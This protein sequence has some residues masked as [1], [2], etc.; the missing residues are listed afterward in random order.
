MHR[1]MLWFL[2]INVMRVC[3]LLNIIG[4]KVLHA[5]TVTPQFFFIVFKSVRAVYFFWLNVTF[6]FRIVNA[7]L[8]VWIVEHLT[9]EL[10]LLLFLIK[11]LDL[12]TLFLHNILTANNGDFLLFFVPTGWDG[13]LQLIKEVLVD[14]VW[15]SERCGL[16][17][18]S[19]AKLHCHLDFALQN[20]FL[21]F[22]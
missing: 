11:L 8:T 12:Q 17:F 21:T 13:H 7:S 4:F 10:L 19:F 1:L 18:L 2:H 5:Q 6:G 15:W 20:V 3:S 14:D 9:I 22:F 16:F